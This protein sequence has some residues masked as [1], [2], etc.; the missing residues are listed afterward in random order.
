MAAMAKMA[1]LAVHGYILGTVQ[2]NASQPATKTGGLMR[3]SLTSYGRKCTFMN[4]DSLQPLQTVW[5]E[6]P[7]AVGA[8]VGVEHVRAA[9]FVIPKPEPKRTVASG[10][11][12]RERYVKP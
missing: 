2:F 7:H 9:A 8:G 12:P 11:N 5:F 4:R 10:G 3:P 1:R 6:P